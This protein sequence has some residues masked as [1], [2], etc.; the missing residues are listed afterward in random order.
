MMKKKR[1]DEKGV[2]EAIKVRLEGRKDQ[3]Y[4]REYLSWIFN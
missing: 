4:S 2:R 3:R 1:S